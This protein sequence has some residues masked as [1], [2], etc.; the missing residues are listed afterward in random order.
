M[1]IPII[2]K[3]TR[4]SVFGR[5]GVGKT[6]LNKWLMLHSPMRWIVLDTKYDD[7]FNNYKIVNKLPSM[8]DIANGIK[9]SKFYVVRPKPNE[10]S[11]SSILD[12]WLFDIH[13]GFNNIGVNIDEG[14]QVA[15]GSNAGPGLTGLLT[16]GRARGQSVIVG[17][18]RP[19]RLPLFVFT[20]ANHYFVMQLSS[21]D[22]KK[23]VADYTGKREILKERI[24]PRHWMHFNV[25][26]GELVRYGPVSFT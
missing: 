6:T 22:D 4:A 13:D 14:Y 20:E 8:G 26:S 3:G 17:S 1:K 7:A 23:K 15:L 24:E 2:D 25:A 18:Q 10:I 9:N 12:D 19:A 5:S 16:R 11:N 21:L